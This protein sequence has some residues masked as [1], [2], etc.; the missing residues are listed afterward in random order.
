MITSSMYIG[1]DL[2]FLIKNE[3][4]IDDVAIAAVG[5]VS[6]SVQVTPLSS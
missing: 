6:T 5:T 1:K 2:E 4:N 3:P